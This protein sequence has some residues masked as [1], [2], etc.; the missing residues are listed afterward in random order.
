MKTCF[1]C[2]AW[3]EYVDYGTD[4]PLCAAHRRMGSEKI[5][6]IRRRRQILEDQWR[7]L[8]AIQRW[9]AGSAYEKD[10]AMAKRLEG[11]VR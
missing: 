4:E 9:H 11:V 8:A 3:A 2:G 10:M 7:M 6:V 1:V 5:R